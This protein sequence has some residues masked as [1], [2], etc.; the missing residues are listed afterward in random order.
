[1][2]PRN[3]IFSRGK[4]WT[5]AAAVGLLA[6]V[7]F[8]PSA[9][10]YTYPGETARIVSGWLGLGVMPYN[11]FPLMA[12]FAR[13]LGCSNALAVISGAVAAIALFHLLSVFLYRRHCTMP[14][15]KSAMNA[16]FG[17]GIWM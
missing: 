16:L 8:V 11:E 10:D 2:P 3:N 15:K 9:A 14:K 6:V 17:Q 7:S 12:L 1:M 4:D 5:I 13:P